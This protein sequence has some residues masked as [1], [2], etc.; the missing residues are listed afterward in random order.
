[1]ARGKV[2]FFHIK[3]KLKPVFSEIVDL[4]AQIQEHATFDNKKEGRKVL[5]HVLVNSNDCRRTFS[6]GCIE[7]VRVFEWRN[8]EHGGHLELIGAKEAFLGKITKCE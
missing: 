5:G 7:S 4:S 2:R 1:M 6:A 8:R 3:K